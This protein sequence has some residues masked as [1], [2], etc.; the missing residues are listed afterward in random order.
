MISNIGLKEVIT[1][2]V[3]G[4]IIFCICREIIL[5]FSTKTKTETTTAEKSHKTETFQDYSLS[6][7]QPR[8]VSQPN[9]NYYPNQGFQ[10]LVFTNT[11]KYPQMVLGSPL[12]GSVGFLSSQVIQK[13]IYPFDIQTFNTDKEMVKA[14]ISNTI[15]MGLVREFEILN[16][17]KGNKLDT[18][19]A[20]A[21]AYYETLFV[22]GKALLPLSSLNSIP[23][24]NYQRKII[25]AYLDRDYDLVNN[26][27]TFNNID[28]SVET[29]KVVCVN[30]PTILDI[31]ND[32]IIGNIDI[33]CI[34]CH[35]KNTVLQEMMLSSKNKLLKII[36][37][38]ILQDNV[39][40]F[41]KDTKKG[42]PWIFF[43]DTYPVIKMPQIVSSGNL[44]STFQVRSLLVC[45]DKLPLEKEIM[46]EIVS[47]LVENYQTLQ[48][49]VEKW[50]AIEGGDMLIDNTDKKSFDF[51]ALSTIPKELSIHLDMVK[52]LQQINKIKTQ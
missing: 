36:D 10:P 18:I 38:N 37:T 5:N 51:D 25:I 12:L 2:L 46:P 6:K 40:Q 50:N 16:H 47:N 20:L 9:I 49:N 41:K 26:I 32:Y 28:I 15:Q 11:R 13:Y 1:I 21:P 3:L 34:C 22:I 48:L 17:L 33:I 44:Y 14:L 27:L 39:E 35:P 8:P 24:S 42:F 4:I 45:N 19:T 31:V 23:T 7:S 29:E 30:Y 52:I 43:T